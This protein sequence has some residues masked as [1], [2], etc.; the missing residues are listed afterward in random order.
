MELLETKCRDEG[1]K[2][3][4]TADLAI[5]LKMVGVRAEQPLRRKLE[6]FV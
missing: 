2:Q 6:E 4:L 3:R 5:M 1:E